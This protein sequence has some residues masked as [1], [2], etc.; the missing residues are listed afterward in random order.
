MIIPA[1]NEAGY[2]A[3]CL[4][5]LLRSDTAAAFETVVV[6]NGC[7]DAT[8]AIARQTAARL[9]RAE[10]PVR[11]I[12]RAEGGKP[13]AL[14]CGDAAAAAPIRVYLDA[15]VIVSPGLIGALIAALDTDAPRFAGGRPEI[16]PAQSA[17]TRAYARF[18][19]RL[20]FFRSAVPGFGLFAVNA[21]G[22]GRWGV[23]PAIISDDTFARL[24][25]TPEERICVPHGYRWPMAEGL[26]RLVAVRRRQDRGVAE[27]AARYPELMRNRDRAETGLGRKLGAA[28]ADPVGLA[29]YAL[30]ALC[31]RLPAPGAP[32]GGSGWTRGR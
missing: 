6:A 30:V 25:F 16:A 20:P 2:I 10:R 21:A 12:E 7:R 5:A 26:G 1:S 11:V 32:R 29:V 14:Q 18:W 19:Q 23:W 15:D 13:G 27:I 31:V 3:A 17:L 8:A 9:A 28:L 24:H 22:R 4:E